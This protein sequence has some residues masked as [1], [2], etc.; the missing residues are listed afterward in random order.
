VDESVV[1][2]GGERLVS[3]DAATCES[4]LGELFEPNDRRFRYPFINCT[5]C[6]PRFTIIEALPYDRERTSMRAFPMCAD[7]AREYHD[8]AD[9]RFHAEPIACPTCGPRLAILDRLGGGQA[10]DPIE[11]AATLLADGGIVALKGLGGFHLACDATDESAVSALRER[12]RRPDKP[13]AV[14]VADLD[15]A[16]ERFV[17]NALERT[18]LSSSRAPIVLVQDRGTLAPSVAPGHRRQGAML[19]STPLHHLLLR[20]VGRPLIMTSGNR[21]DE[22]ICIENAEALER[23]AEVPGL[24]IFG[25]P[26]S[27]GR[28]GPECPPVLGVLDRMDAR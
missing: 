16:A 21:S 20:E 17:L 28:L 26:A 11:Q 7:C 13:F 24:K 6:G 14:M 25:P 23:L 2:F 18:E 5:D 10:G 15:D 9:R 8:P 19:P 27:P 12:K 1:G 4:F 3:A 22:P